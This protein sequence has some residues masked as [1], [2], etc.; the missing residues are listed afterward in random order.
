MC[1]FETVYQQQGITFV[2]II[3]T[4]TSETMLSSCFSKVVLTLIRYYMF[5]QLCISQFNVNYL[6]K[7]KKRKTGVTPVLL[8]PWQQHN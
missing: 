1:D 7:G 8:L 4:I 3:F 5:A 2:R 6:L